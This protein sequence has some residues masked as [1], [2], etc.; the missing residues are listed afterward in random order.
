MKHA[1]ILMSVS[2]LAAS[3]TAATYYVSPSGNDNNAG[4]EDAPVKTIAKGISKATQAGDIVSVADGDYEIGAK[5][6][7]SQA[8]T[9]RGNVDDCSKVVVNC[10]G[11]QHALYNDSVD[12]WSV[13]GFTF[14][15]IYR[16]VYSKKAVTVSHCVFRDVKSG[17]ILGGEALCFPDGTVDGRKIVEDCLFDNLYSGGKGAIYLDK[18][19]PISVRRCIFRGCYGGGIRQNQDS[20]GGGIELT[21]E[22]CEFSDCGGWGGAV[23]LMG[24]NK[25]TQYFRNCLFVRNDATP[26]GWTA[27]GS[28]VTTKN[29]YGVYENCTFADNTCSKSPSTSAA[30]VYANGG[31]ST[32]VNC[33]FWNNLHMNGSGGPVTAETSVSG[34]YTATNCAASVA[35]PLANGT[36][37]KAL[38]ASPFAAAGVYTLA[39]KIGEADNP[40]LG[41]GVKLD[42]MTED[43]KD[44]AGN[45]RLREDD[46]V[47]LG[48]YEFVETVASAGFLMLI[49]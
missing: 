18:I 8:I 2:L 35:S 29:S 28:A 9:I 48:C 17:S 24:N 4:T 30:A 11:T 41:A 38:S 15:N 44:L 36:D 33:I 5:I 6:T 21:T 3:A 19:F 13:S 46:I 14:T 7:V 42:W 47:D 20:T 22:D 37:N 49:D 26:N 31:N 34:T 12:G 27:C 1:L 32:F 45:P 23:N 16:V 39:Q 25:K 10:K 40:C 43:S